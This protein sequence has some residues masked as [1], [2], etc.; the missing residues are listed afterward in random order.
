MINFVLFIFNTPRY[1]M[2]LQTG[3]PFLSGCPVF[4]L[5]LAFMLISKKLS[6]LFDISRS[7]VNIG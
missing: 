1:T 3:Q 6:R 7:L 2:I 4:F 5:Y